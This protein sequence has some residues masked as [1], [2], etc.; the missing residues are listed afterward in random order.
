[1]TDAAD[2]LQRLQSGG[3]VA[4]ADTLAR[5]EAKPE[6]DESAAI[7]DAAFRH[8]RAHVVGLT[9]PPGVGKSTLIKALINH[10]RERGRTVG[11]IAV[12]PSSRKSGGALLGDRTRFVT[13]PT[14]QGVFVRSM[15]ARDRLGGIAALTIDVMVVMRAVF[16]V[17]L[18]ETVGV[19]Q[20]ETDVST[21]AD[22]VLFCVQPG[23]GD[24]LQYMK[25]GIMEIPD[26]I[27]VTKGDMDAEARRTRS[28]VENALALD[29]GSRDGWQL[30]ILV[31]SALR[32]NGMADLL[33]AVD[34]HWQH[35]IRGHR[36]RESRAQ[37]AKAW[38][39]DRIQSQFG[40]FGLA[41]IGNKLL[42]TEDESPFQKERELAS[43]LKGAER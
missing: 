29:G 2:L 6:A 27:V 13:D 37:Q 15:A 11:V 39:H 10:W 31:I 23:S 4:L 14:D 33:D 7:L 12:D 24:T 30:P 38:L 17:V 40:S 1:M 25:A 41:R 35:M 16:D 43:S 3:K 5:L 36:L 34:R 28:D 18:I 32:G 9:G 26:I 22:T 8:P 42:M 20:S 19:G 21:V